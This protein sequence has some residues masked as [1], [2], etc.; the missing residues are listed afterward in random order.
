MTAAPASRVGARLLRQGATLAVAE[1]CTGGLL[2]AQV[3][4]VSGSSAYFLGG[5][6]SYSNEAKT[7]FLG[8]TPRLLAARGAVSEETAVAMARGVRRA[9]GADYGVGITGIA[10]PGGGVPGKPVGTVCLA[11]AGPG[12]VTVRRHLFSG[13]RG[14]VRRA[15]CR[16]AFEMLD[17]RLGPVA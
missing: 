11:V 5:V 14:A 15:A 2:G 8:V 10:G 17:E 6:I 9:F 3:T 4:A 13:G 12:G 16:K 7:R 1:S